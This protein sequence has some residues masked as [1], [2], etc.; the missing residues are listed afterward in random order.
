M[1]IWYKDLRSNSRDR[2][3]EVRTL[4]KKTVRQPHPQV[5]PIIFFKKA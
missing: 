3:R 4:V 1:R 2:G 5:S